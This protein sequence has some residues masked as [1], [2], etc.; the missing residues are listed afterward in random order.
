MKAF[1]FMIGLFLIPVVLFLPKALKAQIKVDYQQKLAAWSAITDQASSPFAL[2]LVV[3]PQLNANKHLKK[4]LLLDAEASCKLSGFQYYKDKSFNYS[5]NLLPYRAWLRLSSNAF[6]LR[7]GLQKISFGSARTFRPL[8]WFD[9]LDPRDPLQLSPGVWAGLFRYYFPSN[10]NLWLWS[11]YSSKEPFGWEIKAGNP[12]YPEFGGRFQFPLKNGE[13]GVAYHHRNATSDAFKIEQNRVGAD[14]K[15]DAVVSF[16]F[17]GFYQNEMSADPLRMPHQFIFNSGL[18]YTF[19]LIDGLLVSY[20]LLGF[21]HLKPSENQLI[22]KEFSIFS[23]S[24]KIGN[25]DQLML[26]TFFDH[27][28]G[29]IFPFLSYHHTYNSFDLSLMAYDL[30]KEMILINPQE[31]NT[32]LSG[33]VIQIMIIYEIASK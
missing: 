28:A 3:I 16:W 23:A 30:P 17:E 26:M 9:K 12:K 25:F 1:R 6:E 8:M 2:G 14:A 31:T 18:D 21:Y 33:K 22:N 32:L 29:K 19:P 7:I 20:E 13:I 4:S 5:G 10:A 24:L 15:F 27:H 11:V